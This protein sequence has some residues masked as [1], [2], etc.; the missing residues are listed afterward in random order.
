MEEIVKNLIEIQDY[1]V[2]KLDTYEQAIYHYIFR[3]TYLMGEQSTLFSNKRA[4]IGFGSGAEGTPPSESSRSKKLRSLEQKGAVKIL[5]RSHKGMLV[6]IILP[7]DIEGLI[8]PSQEFDINLEHLDFYKDKRL[9]DSILER[10]GY[11]CFYTGKIITKDTCYLDHVIAQ[12]VRGNN[13]YKNIVA[14]CYDANSMKNNKPVEEFTRQLYKDDILSLEEF[15][16]L[17][18]KI[19]KLQNGDLV[20]NLATVKDALGS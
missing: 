10:E 19:Q 18:M 12:S 7:K 5:D 4:Q 8:C 14:S 15:N 9:L 1:L 16:Q 2:P 20:P 13:S 17:K 6:S 3:H 11:R